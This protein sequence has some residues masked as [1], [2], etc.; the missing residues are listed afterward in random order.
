MGDWKQ[1]A[2]PIWLFGNSLAKKST[3]KFQNC[4]GILVC[5]CLSKAPKLAFIMKINRVV[6]SNSIFSAVIVITT[7]CLRVSIVPARSRFIIVIVIVGM[8]GVFVALEIRL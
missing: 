2:E 3:R 5:S 6:T 7:A 1:T 8:N 4:T